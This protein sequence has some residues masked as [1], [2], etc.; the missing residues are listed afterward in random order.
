MSLDR[1]KAI[2]LLRRQIATPDA[3]LGY[4]S[5]GYTKWFAFT[6][7][8]LKKTFPNDNAY[9]QGFHDVLNTHAVVEKGHKL[10][11]VRRKALLEAFI[12]EL[13]LMPI[14]DKSSTVILDQQ[15][16][17]VAGQTF[18]ALL[19]AAAIIDTARV[20][21][22]LIDNFFDEK[23]LQL[24]SGKRSGVIAEIVAR[25]RY[26]TLPQ[27]VKLLCEAFHKQHGGLEVRHSDD[28]HDR[29]VIIDGKEV[30]HFG[31]SFN[32]LGSRGFMFSRIEESVLVTA[33]MQEVDR[34]W[35]AASV[36]FP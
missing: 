12:D 14:E 30:Y 1:E 16:F 36:L 4:E 3:D 5:T 25:P 7:S 20:S 9:A 35:T 27:N 17:Y 29:F 24:L 33:L 15:G 32:H 18:D 6:I 13:E 2:Q 34:A 10:A 28:F 21:V 11:L 22:R 23:V 31:A 26:G 19:K 8:L